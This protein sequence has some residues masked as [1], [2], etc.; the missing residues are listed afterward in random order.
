MDGERSGKMVKI[1][2]GTGIASGWVPGIAFIFLS[3]KVL[4]R[5]F[6]FHEEFGKFGKCLPLER[7]HWPCN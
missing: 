4:K 3:F 2:S 7:R 1:G 6:N 5:G